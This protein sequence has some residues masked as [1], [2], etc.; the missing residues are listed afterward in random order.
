MKVLNLVWQETNI[1]YWTET[2]FFGSEF[3]PSPNVMLAMIKDH[4]GDF[5][6]VQDG[7]NSDQ[8]PSNAQVRYDEVLKF[9]ND[10]NYRVIEIP[11]ITINVV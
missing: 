11:E 5:K 10:N 7:L 2:T 4:F 8:S 6:S 3:S 9:L 1:D